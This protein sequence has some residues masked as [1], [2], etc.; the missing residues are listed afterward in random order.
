MMGKSYSVTKIVLSKQADKCGNG[1]ARGLS[2][3]ES[4]P[5]APYFLEKFARKQQ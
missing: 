2:K 4:L 1:A 3:S 5:A